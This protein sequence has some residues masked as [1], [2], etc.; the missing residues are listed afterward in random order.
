MKY[1]VIDAESAITRHNKNLVNFQEILGRIRQPQENI[2]GETKMTLD[3]YLMQSGQP[4]SFTV[5][6]A[7]AQNMG[8]N[9]AGTPEQDD[10]LLQAI[11]GKDQNKNDKMK[12]DSENQYKEK[13]FGLKEKQLLLEEKK[14]NTLKAPTADEIADK[15]LN[16][17]SNS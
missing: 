15:I 17:F 3:S 7:M 16:K 13:E 10:L 6:Q 2:N 8:M 1:P 14:M 9:Y 4:T 5:K 11:Q 12:S